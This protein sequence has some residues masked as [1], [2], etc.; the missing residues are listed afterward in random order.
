MKQNPFSF[1]FS[2]VE[3]VVAISIV[4][5]LAAMAMPS[6]KQLIE[7][8]RVKSASFELYASL[9]SARSEALKRNGNVTINAIS[10]TWENGWQITAGGT[11]IK[12]HPALN[13]IVISNAPS[14]IV[15]KK[16]GRLSS[17][18]S[19]SFQI[20]TTPTNTDVSRCTSIDLSGLPR[21]KKGA[22]S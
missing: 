19:P 2:L 14:S 16:N 10:G 13:K 15:F 12:D 8:Q 18:S 1:G 22:C 21:T 4:S 6:F 11:V 7:N 5:I 17:G 20:D 3:L 9:L